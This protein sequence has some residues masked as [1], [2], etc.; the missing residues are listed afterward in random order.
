MFKIGTCLLLIIMSSV[1]CNPQAHAQKKC[2]ASL[3]SEKLTGY[4]NQS[5]EGSEQHNG[6][7]AAI[8]NPAGTGLYAFIE[9]AWAEAAL[10]K[11]GGFGVTG[12][13]GG[14]INACTG[15]EICGL[16]APGRPALSAA[17][18]AQ[19][20]S[21]TLPLK[22]PGLGT[23]PTS[24]INGLEIDTAVGYPVW[25][26]SEGNTD[27]VGA[28][29]SDGDLKVEISAAI[30]S[31]VYTMGDG[32]TLT[33]GTGTKWSKGQAGKPSPTCGHTYEKMGTYM[34]TATTTWN[35]D[36]AAAGETGSIELT[37]TTTRSYRV[38]EIQ[39]LIRKR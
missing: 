22:A 38:G 14:G 20:A 26:W 16:A 30:A 24:E 34:I 13:N 28:S 39:A 15:K 35:A 7:G 1:F 10:K 27:K 8:R 37:R 29:D 31:V 11:Y 5:S 33:C 4:C 32:T 12:T 6:G 19:R 17:Q 36:W 21:A 25:L 2:A 3:V 18:L 9:K 23:G